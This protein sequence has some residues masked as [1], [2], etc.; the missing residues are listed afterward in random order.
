MNETYKD[1]DPEQSV[2]L[3]ERSGSILEFTWN[4]QKKMLMYFLFFKCFK[5]SIN[6]DF[7]ISP[8]FLKQFWIHICLHI[9]SLLYALHLR[10]LKLWF[11]NIWI[12]LSVIHFCTHSKKCHQR[13]HFH[14]S[15]H[16]SSSPSRRGKQ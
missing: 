16:L 6:L 3:L 12:L 14:Y 10:Y 9:R 4:S 5:R 7:Y 15:Y 11:I 8:V 1:S 2:T 13:R